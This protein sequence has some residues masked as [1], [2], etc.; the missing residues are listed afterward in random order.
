MYPSRRARAYPL[1]VAV[2]S[3]HNGR[4][5]VLRVAEM[6]WEEM[7]DVPRDRAVAI[8]P[9][10][11]TEAHG[12]HLPL[13]TDVIIAEA[14]ARRGAELLSA[15]GAHALLLPALA[16]TAA[17]YAEGFAG[18]VSIRPETVTALLVDIARG[19]SGHARVVA[20][21]NAHLDPTHI[22]SIYAAREA[23][24]DAPLGFV[25]PDVT[26]KPWALRLTDEFK[27]GACHAG[28]YEGSVVMAE[29][30][31]LVRE[32]LRRALTPNPNSL[33][34]A[35]RAGLHS[36]EQAGGPRA[37]FGDPAAATAAEGRDTVETLGRILD[38]AVAAA[39]GEL[40]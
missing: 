5:P 13:G 31:D 23:L 34:T 3:R 7:R 35:I 10:G 17:G 8:V 39:M 33:S 1:P 12:P 29:R 22:G 28:Q 27:S 4:M 20:V 24:E 15:R 9:V 14:M 37:Y 18:T 6:T 30:P 19:M 38:E 11:A 40:A 36:F 25:F 21:A 32:D 16:Y 2:R 26:R